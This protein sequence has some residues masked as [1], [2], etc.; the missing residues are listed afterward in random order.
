MAAAGRRSTVA[1]TGAAV[2]ADEWPPDSVAARLFRE[3]F[4]FDFFQAVRLLERLRP[5]SV[6]V[7]RAGPPAA[8]AVRFRAR[9]T[10]AFPPSSIYS[11]EAPDGPDPVP[12]LTVTFMGLTGPNG[13]LPRAYTELLM[14]LEKDLRGP[15]KFALRDWLDLFNHRFISLFFRAWEKYRLDVPYARRRGRETEPDPFTGCLLSLAGFG[16]PELRDRL[17]VTSVRVEGRGQIREQVLA[18]VETFALAYYSGLLSHR[19]R[20]ALGL[21]ALLHDYFKLPVRVVQFQG[22]WLR[23]RADKQSRLGDEAGLARLGR[24]AVV[25]ARVW[26]VQGKIRVRLGPLTYGQ[27]LTLMPDRRPFRERKAFFELAHVVRTYA[28]PE[29]DF[30]VQLVLKAEEV[31]DLRLPVETEEGPQLGWNSWLPAQSLPRD[32]EEGVFEGEEVVCVNRP[33]ASL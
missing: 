29:L 14:R 19:P 11:L 1:L 13:V 10:L 17:R 5:K 20:S 4:G 15:E 7:G 23:L 9:Q 33:L 3:G 21:A 16:L 24:T 28:G 30:D 18:R 27:Y 12:A 31:P 26:D 6:P 8:E 32:A 25:G 22:E 2:P